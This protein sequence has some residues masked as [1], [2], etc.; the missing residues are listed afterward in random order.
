M[1]DAP[2]SSRMMAAVAA[3]DEASSA[4]SSA[5]DDAAN[6]RR[7]CIS[8]GPGGRR[9]ALKKSK[10]AFVRRA[11][12]CDRKQG[13]G[14]L[15]AAGLP[16]PA[17]PALPFDWAACARRRARRGRRDQT[18][19]AAAAAGDAPD[20]P[21]RWANEDTERD[22]RGERGRGREGR[23]GKPKKKHHHPTPTPTNRTQPAEP[24]RSP[25]PATSSNLTSARHEQKYE[26][27]HEQQ[28][29][30]AGTTACLGRIAASSR[31]CPPRRPLPPT[32]PAKTSPSRLRAL[33]ASPYPAASAMS[34]GPAGNTAKTCH[35][36]SP[37]LTFDKVGQKKAHYRVTHQSQ[38]TITSPDNLGPSS[39]CPPPFSIASRARVHEG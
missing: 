10:A 39:S 3:A 22:E 31:F 7:A 13:R 37:P 25:P 32:S 23:E 33:M 9:E 14:R 20:R 15:D 36:C 8:P 5:D 12:A 26:Q 2:S 28:H 34:A 18:A 4:S 24:H 38:T 35:H 1:P 19:A 16:R 27:Q 11:F 6:G 21:G 30:A 17:G 29:Q